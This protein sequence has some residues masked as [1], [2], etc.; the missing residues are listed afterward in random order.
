VLLPGL[1]NAHTHLELSW[2]AGRIR[3][4]ASIVDWIRTLMAERAAGPAGG[5]VTVTRAA[6]AAAADM[7]R[8][9]T[10]LVGDISNS[11]I[12]P[13]ILREAGLGGIVFHEIVGFNVQAAML[14]VQDAW[15][16]VEAVGGSSDMP[17]DDARGPALQIGVVGH[18]P[19]SV[20]AALMSEIA[21]H[22]RGVPLS[23]HVAESA[24]EIEFLR[25]G[26]GPFRELLEDLDVWNPAW[27]VP[28][29]D[30]VEYLR[31]VDYLKAG[32]LAVHAVH[33][34]DDA[35]DALREA[36]AVVVTC[37]RSNEWV[38]GGIPRVTH[39]Y[40]AGIPVAI[41][42]DSL[43]SVPSVSLFDELAELRRIAPDVTAASLLDSATR[44]GAEALGR[45]ADYGT[46][47]PGRRA[48]LVSVAI[49][50]GTTDV[51]EYLVSGVPPA[52]V[53]PIQG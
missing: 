6:R 44:V 14:V 19:Y 37:P 28:Q 25:S 45:G 43:A 29:C 32:L 21:R 50:P 1:V 27:E 2:L 5:D 53:R 7:R 51:E 13:A 20:S 8:C 35:L 9:G 15:R 52:A 11:L 46:L 3:P 26:S 18:A 30:P 12:S 42:T 31:Q 47:A 33:L 40:A 34:T 48:R 49:P 17:S 41:G 24:E 16:R 38:G 4:T 22:D 39:F 23:V 10:V 36:G